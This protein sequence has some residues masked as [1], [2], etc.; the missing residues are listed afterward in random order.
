MDTEAP[1]DKI[2]ESFSETEQLTVLREMNENIKR[3]QRFTGMMHIIVLAGL[4]LC[5]VFAMIALWRGCE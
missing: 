3:I 4:F 1:K 5:A 2:H